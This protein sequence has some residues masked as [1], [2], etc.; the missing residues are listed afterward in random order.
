[1]GTTAR[2]VR[3]H[4]NDRFP[5]RVAPQPSLSDRTDPVVYGTT[6]DGPLDNST[7]TQYKENGF[8]AFDA[9]FSE[10]ELGP[11][12]AE[13][14]RM[15]A[16][17][18]IRAMPS[19]I[20]EPGSDEDVR[21]IFA[22]HE[23]NEILGRLCRDPRLVSIARQLMGGDVYFQQ[24]RINYKPGF[25][26]K[27]F[28]WH[29]DFE[30]W[31]VEDG[32]PGMRAVSCSISLTPNTP[33]NGPLMLIPGSHKQFLSCVGETPEEHYK[34]SLKI[35]EL[36]VPDKDN[37]A[38]MVAEGGIQAPVG[39]AGSVTF[40][41]CNLMHGSNSN[42]TPFARS[43]VFIVFNHCDNALVEPFC[44]LPPRPQF[45]ANRT[46]LSPIRLH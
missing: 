18:D 29:S 27:P 41:D 46:D 14:D 11:W 44:G 12:R 7:L 17:P 4:H 16:D 37:L 38:R 32:M 15:R 2:H 31:H 45:I 28:Y 33:E 43:N 13:L 21:S 20:T 1:M 8:L 23:H 19:T 34:K 9:F 36:G 40:F 5:S 39:P 10:A 24:S 3:Q 30:T 25:K 35:Q 6:K 26:G 42:I 22:I